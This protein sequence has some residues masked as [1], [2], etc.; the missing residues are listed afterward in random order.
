MV[1][2]NPV[3]ITTARIEEIFLHFAE[4]GDE[5]IAKHLCECARNAAYT[6][7]TI[8]NDIIAIT[9]EY[10][11]NQIVSEIPE[12]APFFTMKQLTFRILNSFGCQF[13]L[14]IK[15]VVYMKNFLDL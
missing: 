3:R 8:Q 13:N 4:G 1:I 5:L 11:R 9:M 14:S 10:L 7:A 12:H 2:W 15:L 6:S